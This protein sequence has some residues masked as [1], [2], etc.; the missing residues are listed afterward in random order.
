MA[1]IRRWLPVFASDKRALASG[2]AVAPYALLLLLVPTICCDSQCETPWFCVGY[3]VVAA[4]SLYVLLG[5]G[6]EL[7][8]LDERLT[9]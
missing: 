7:R 8:L 5:I 9:F 1:R 3:S 6:R 4:A 2:H